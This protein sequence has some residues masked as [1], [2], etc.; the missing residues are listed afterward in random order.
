M[1]DSE[2]TQHLVDA[3]TTA[4]SPEELQAHLALVDQRLRELDAARIGLLEANPE[5]VAQHPELQE[6]LDRLRTLDIGA[7]SG[8]GS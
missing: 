7:A 1:F 3:D 8:P 6:E 4:M 2:I 5:V